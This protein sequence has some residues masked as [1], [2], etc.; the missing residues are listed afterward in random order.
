MQ[1][2]K[3]NGLIINLGTM[4][5][6]TISLC[7]FGDDLI[8]HLWVTDIILEL[9]QHGDQTKCLYALLIEVRRNV[10]IPI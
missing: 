5:S 7:L 10:N 8:E 2:C 3:G 1:S 9:N 4:S 6:R